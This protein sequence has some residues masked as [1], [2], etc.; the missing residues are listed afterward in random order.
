MS[1]ADLSL[2]ELLYETFTISALLPYQRDII[3]LPWARIYTTNYD[4]MVSLVKGPNFP[5]FTFDEPRPRRLP[6]AFS[7]CLHGSIRR[8]NE[9]NA[10]D[11][12]ILNN[13]S[14][15]VISVSIHTGL[16]SFNATG[17]LSR[18][19]TSWVLASVIITFPD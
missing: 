8:A 6:L 7:G 9:E 1:R 2:Y 18:R 11:Q 17:G 14:Y 13:K 12:L 15:D 19:V 4:D 16:K 5:V 10:G 3:S